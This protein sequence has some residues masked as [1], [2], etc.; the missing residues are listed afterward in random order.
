[1]SDHQ[2]KIEA[3]I[4]VPILNRDIIF[5]VHSGEALLGTLRISRGTVEWCPKNHRYGYHLRWES[6][7][8]TMK[9]FGKRRRP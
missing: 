1:M 3:E 5:K 6:F 4:K 7:A 9:N 8:E 2:L